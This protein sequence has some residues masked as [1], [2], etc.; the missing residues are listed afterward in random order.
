MKTMI[1]GGMMGLAACAAWGDSVSYPV[2]DTGQIR[3]YD[4]RTE[5]EYPKS[6]Q[7]FFGQDAEYN[8]LQPSYRDNGD[9]TVTDLNTGLMWQA[10]P[11]KKKT[12][13]EIV[14]DVKKC[15]TGGYS[16][17]RLP[18]IK[19][20]YS[21]I[22]FSGADV[23]PQGRQGRMPFIDANVFKFSYGKAEDGDRIIDSQWATS[24]IYVGRVMHGQHAMFGVNFAD[25]RIKGYP[26]GD[27]PGRGA[28]TFYAIYVR[29]NP[30]YGKNDFV[31][32]GDGTVTD[33]ATGLTW[34]QADSGKGMDWPSALDYAETMKFAGHDDWR[35]PNAK[36]LQSI[37]DYSRSPDTTHS[38]AID[39]VF[40][41]TK[42]KNEDGQKDYGHY[43]SS[44]THVSPRGGDH[45]VYV[46]FGRAL[47]FMHNRWM[48][49]HGAGAQRSDPKSGDESQL[50]KGHGPQGDAQRIN[51]MVRLVRGGTAESRTFGPKVEAKSAPR[52]R[53][54]VGHLDRNGDGKVSRDEFD[55]PPDQFDILDKNHDGYLSESEAPPPPGRMRR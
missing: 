24:T 12:Y 26:T 46:A 33:R 53:G 18:T 4:D 35:L 50:P 32:N 6:G 29:D 13:G 43:W 42:I 2:V 3:C 54:F 40:K 39:P 5:I 20:L 10:D 41:C 11:G 25:G 36:E 47:G 21:L 14:A 37:V 17:W 7:P 30:D 9:G 1:M 44:T 28:K 48:D 27:M 16:D 52:G 31:D 49:V 15:R 8:G 34:M 19:E 23:D 22:D 51:N 45:A 55:G 38:A